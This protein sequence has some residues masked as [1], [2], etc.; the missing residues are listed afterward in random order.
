MNIAITGQPGSGK[1]T[2][3]QRLTQALGWK[4]SGFR[5]YPY[6]I[7]GKKRGYY[8]H[9]LISLPG[10]TN[11]LPISEIKASGQSRGIA[12]TFRTL[13]TKCLQQTLHSTSDCIIMDEIG[14]FEQNVPEFLHAVR[15]I[16]NQHHK[17]VFIVLKKE[18][19]PFVLEIKERSDCI[20]IDLDIVDR[21]EA[22][23]MLLTKLEVRK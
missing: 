12:E 14:R 8:L 1:S 22:Y 20:H 6:E 18:P 5:T 19:I 7:S 10:Q 21:E 16:L 4:C 11:D 17:P 23:K 13:G 2:L 15:A 9:S 3:V